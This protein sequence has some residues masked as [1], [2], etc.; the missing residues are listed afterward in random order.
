[1]FQSIPQSLN[2]IAVG[3]QIFIICPLLGTRTTR[4]N[5]RLNIIEVQELQKMVSVIA[6]IAKKC[7]GAIV[8]NKPLG[9]RNISIVTGSQD[10]L[11]R[12]T[13]RI[14]QSMQFGGE[15]TATT[16]KT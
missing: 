1:M 5:N 14:A 7:R 8:A 11:Y 12:I 16:S 6:F 2:F 10:K 15:P 9:M 13:Q 3:V 4:R